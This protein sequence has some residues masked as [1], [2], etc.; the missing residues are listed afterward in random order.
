MWLMRKSDEPIVVKKA[1]NSVGA[2]GFY[3]I[4]AYSEKEQD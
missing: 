1:G 4:K 2:K 3:Q